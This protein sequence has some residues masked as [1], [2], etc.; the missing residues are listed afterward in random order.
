[1]AKPSQK[2][3]DLYMAISGEIYGG[4]AGEIWALGNS[5]QNA[6]DN[7]ADAFGLELSE[8]RELEFYKVCKIEVEMKMTIAEKK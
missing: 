6:A 1:M 2:Q 4:D 3:P 8:K 7:A 5:P